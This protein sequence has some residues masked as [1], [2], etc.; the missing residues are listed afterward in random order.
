MHYII[1]K[2]WRML[3]G[4]TSRKRNSVRGKKIDYREYH[5]TC[6]E[7]AV[8]W[9]QMTVAALLN[10]NIFYRNRWALL[11]NVTGGQLYVK[12]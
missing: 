11:G 7:W 10:K 3:F 4:T 8:C 12:C 6:G 9:T 5:F 2:K 1:K